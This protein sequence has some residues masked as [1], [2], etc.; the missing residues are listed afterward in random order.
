MT[1]SP[2]VLRLWIRPAPEAPPEERDALALEAGAGVVGDH[3]FG[4]MRHVTIVFED[5]WNRAA[6]TLGP[7]PVDPAG[8]RANVLVSGGGGADWIGRTVRLGDA[9]VR[10][11]A[12]TAP[13]PVM[14]RAAKGM[15]K[16]LEPDAGAGVWGRVETS[17]RV[18][19][20]AVLAVD[21]GADA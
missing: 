10:I 16:A 5:D 2:Q 19:V 13:C 9:V 3:T 17:G 1:D 20:G 12:E 21:E 11:K 6:A 4:R 15:M 8:R 18:A 14:E 7:D